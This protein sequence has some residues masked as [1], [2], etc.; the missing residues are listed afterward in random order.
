MSNTIIVARS[1]AGKATAHDNVTMA[2]EIASDATRID[3]SPEAML[4]RLALITEHLRAAGRS[5]SLHVGHNRNGVQRRLLA[6]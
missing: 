6:L 5:G 3:D 4:H 1:T 2:L